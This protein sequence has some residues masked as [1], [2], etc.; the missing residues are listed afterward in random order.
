ML[1]SIQF[2]LWKNCCHNCDFCFNIYSKAS[3]QKD[4][5]RI[6]RNTKF[7][8]E[9]K[10]LTKY[11]RIGFIGGE[12]LDPRQFEEK[13]LILF[14]ELIDYIKDVLDQHP[15]ITFYITTALLFEDLTLVKYLAE[16][17]S[18]LPSKNRWYICTSYDSKGRFHNKN[19]LN[20]FYKNMKFLQQY[21][22]NV[23]VEVLPTQHFIEEVLAD[24]F[25]PKVFE[26]EFNCKID[27]SDLNSGF[28][29]KDKFDMQK[30]VPYFFPKRSDFIKFLKKCYQ[31]DLAT[32]KEICYYDIFFNEWYRLDEDLQL[33]LV[34]RHGYDPQMPYGH[35]QK[36]DYIDSDKLMYEDVNE[37]WRIIKGQKNI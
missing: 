28:Y 15:Q 12:L 37:V 22:L 32:P 4:K 27:Y 36:S 30:D 26:K 17:V 29:W 19:H 3:T 35:V 20:L 24:R 21:G 31:E 25:N 33:Q 23:H 18:K 16:Y 2:E 10:D 14:K 11:E 34:L 7:C 1:N 13:T 8:L 5:R 6:L 9:T